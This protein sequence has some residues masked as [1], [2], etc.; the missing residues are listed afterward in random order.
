MSVLR[1]GLS[2]GAGLSFRVRT[3]GPMWSP[4]DMVAFAVVWALRR[5][6]LVIGDSVYGTFDMVAFGVV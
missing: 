6:P 2:C 1:C 3:C 4:F 5:P